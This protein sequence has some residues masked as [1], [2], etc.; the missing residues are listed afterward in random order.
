MDILKFA[1]H[2]LI[3][4]GFI[5]TVF[6]GVLLTGLNNKLVARMQ[7]RVGPPVVQPWYDFLKFCGKE[8]IVPRKAWKPVFLASPV[9]GF[10]VL[11]TVGLFLPAAGLRAFALP[12][13]VIVVLYLLAFVSVMGIVGASASGSPF[14]G[15]GLSREMVAMI[16]YELP[17]VLVI[18][19]VGRLCGAGTPDGVTFSL[20][21]IAQWQAQNGSVLFHWSMIPAALAMLLVIPC[22]IGMHPFDI[23]EAETE[24]CEGTLTEYSGWP[25]AFFRLT[26]T[27][28]VYIMAQLFVSMFLGGTLTGITVLDALI[29]IVLCIAVTFFSCTLPHGVCARLKVE[30]VFRFFWTV[31]TGLALISLV[32]VWLGL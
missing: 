7:S 32:L 24:I 9:I 26:H 13:D 2:I 6:M 23:A 10:S 15:V 12:A 27:V 20:N 30:Q 3:F 21:Q 1:F 8:T 19:A 17:F 29:Q 5:F 4:P 11:L 31:V 18:L 25:L 14:A 22:E 28:K 16:S